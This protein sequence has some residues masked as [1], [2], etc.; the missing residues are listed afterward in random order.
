MKPPS[1]AKHLLIAFLLALVVY[2]G[3]YAL[4][5]SRRA[6]NGPWQ[7]TF[8]QGDLGVPAILI[9]QPRLGI[10][11]VQLRFVGESIP[12][13]NAASATVLFS[14]PKPVPFTVP[15]GECVFMDTTFLPGTVAL[16]LFGHEIELLPRVL[17]IDH[18][19]HGW[20]PNACI[21]LPRLQNSAREGERPREP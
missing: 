17:I 6:R 20:Q 13:T 10:T 3:V 16:R 11:N 15:F 21:T 12:L 5:D 9:H 1:L 18:E 8:S 14:E 19:R 7:V 2:A 4:I